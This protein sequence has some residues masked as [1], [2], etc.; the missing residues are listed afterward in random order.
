MIQDSASRSLPRGGQ[1]GE[2]GPRAGLRIG[3][4]SER[5]RLC[6]SPGRI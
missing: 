1:E 2:E 5:R 4:G 3:A 6:A